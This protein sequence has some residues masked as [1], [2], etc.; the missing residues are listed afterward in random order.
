MREQ[1]AS[2][3][4]L[5]F[6]ISLSAHVSSFGEISRLNVSRSYS[7]TS[8]EMATSWR[9]PHPQEIVPF[10]GLASAETAPAVDH[11]LCCQKPLLPADAKPYAT[12]TVDGAVASQR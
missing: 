1:A 10:G 4:R 3:N 12:H 11:F 6:P 2:D 9:S 7:A 8:P 5:V